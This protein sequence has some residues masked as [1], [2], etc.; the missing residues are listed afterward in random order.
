MGLLTTFDALVEGGGEGVIGGLSWIQLNSCL[1]FSIS[2]EQVEVSSETECS[3]T[4]LLAV[5][6]TKFLFLVV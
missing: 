2:F 4:P 3:S 5:D 1:G 6:S